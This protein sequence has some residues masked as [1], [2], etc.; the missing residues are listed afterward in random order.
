MWKFLRN[1][2]ERIQVIVYKNVWW[3][4]ST[5]KTSDL[6]LSQRARD[7]GEGFCQVIRGTSNKGSEMHFCDNQ[8][9]IRA[10][11]IVSFMVAGTVFAADP[12][13]KAAQKAQPG[14]VKTPPPGTA[15]SDKGFSF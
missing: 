10:L 12:E 8:S 2:A 5:S 13:P 1:D 7:R 9:P 15:P 14:A 3:Q 6:P 4:D 11:A